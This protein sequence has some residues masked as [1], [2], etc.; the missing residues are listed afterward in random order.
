MTL[1]T[2]LTVDDDRTVL[3]AVQA[4]L[5]ERYAERYRIVAAGSGEEGLEVLRELRLRD[6]PVAL[7]LADQRMPGMTGVQLLREAAA[8]HPESK[9]ALLTAYADTEAAIAAINEAGA[10]HYLLKP[11]H[12]PEERLYPVLDDLLETWRPPPMV[13]DLRLIGHR[14]SAGSRAARQFL[15]R[16]LVPYRWVDIERGTDGAELLALAGVDASE[17]P[18]AVLGDG[19]ALVQP[20]LVALAEAVGLRVHAQRATYDLVVVGAGP[21]GLAAGVYG[22]SEGL[23]TL[24]VDQ[25]AAG[26]QAGTSSRIENYLG[27]PAGLSGADLTMRARQQASRFGAEILVPQQAVS[28]TRADPYRIVGFADGSEVTASAVV[29]AAGVD[30][31]TLDVPGAAEL[32]SAGI[33]YAA[34]RAE[35]LDHEGGQVYVVGGGNSAGQAAMYLSAFA[36]QVTLLVR[37]AGLDATM[38]RYLI[39]QLEHTDNVTLRY[40]TSVTECKGTDH[41]EALTIS[42]A[43]GTV[44]TVPADGLFVFIG[45]APRTDWIDDLVARDTAGFVLTG[46]EVGIRPQGWNAPR[47]PLQLETNVPG[48]FVAGDIHA[49][50]MKRVASAVGEG[51]MAVRCVHEHLATL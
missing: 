8:L 21:A 14:W 48:V 17:L 31:R 36:K 16:N 44:E 4:D 18:V 34:G 27:F 20:D 7:V 24:V 40:A 25:T 9:R 35:A 19:T 39:D 28:L 29:I 37:D 49:G 32:T 22:A 23:S 47:P 30:Y 50:S 51:A 1:P 3:A 6:D 38:S 26:G 13:A 15:A 33:Y 43:D 12:P 42:T 41:L 5:R 2:I 10:D 45:M 11:W 46:T